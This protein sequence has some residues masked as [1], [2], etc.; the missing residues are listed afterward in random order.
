MRST[1]CIELLSITLFPV[2]QPRQL[3]ICSLWISL[4]TCGLCK[5]FSLNITFEDSSM[6]WHVSALHSFLWLNNIILWGYTPFCFSISPLVDIWTVSFGYC[7]YEHSHAGIYFSARFQ[8]FQVC[9]A[10]GIAGSYGNSVLNLIE[11]LPN[12][13]RV[14]ASFYVSTSRAYEVSN[15]STSSPALAISIFKNKMHPN[16]CK[17]VVRYSFDLHFPV[18]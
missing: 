12:F 5:S 15:F 6:L 1:Q 4:I 16:S 17:V 8:F 10:G 11:E 3:V 7:S 18:D 9:T 13:S 2:P 14:A